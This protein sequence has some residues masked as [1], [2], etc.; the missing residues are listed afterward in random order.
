MNTLLFLWQKAVD[1][2]LSNKEVKYNVSFKPKQFEDVIGCY[3]NAFE[4]K[5]LGKQAKNYTKK[6]V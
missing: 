4:R 3:Y 6:K 5:L 1:H 2:D